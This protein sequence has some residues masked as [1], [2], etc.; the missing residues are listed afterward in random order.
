MTATKDKTIYDM[1]MT[2]RHDFGL[3]KRQYSLGSSGVTPEERDAL[4][5]DMSQ[6]YS[7]HISRL[8]T[9]WRKLAK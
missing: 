4:I 5:R 1:C 2:W 8:S 3:E 7:H 9:S 6:I